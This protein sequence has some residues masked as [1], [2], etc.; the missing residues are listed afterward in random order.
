MSGVHAL[1]AALAKVQTCRICGL[2][3]PLPDPTCHDGRDHRVGTATGCP[4]CG[5]LQQACSRRPCFGSMHG[6]ARAK[7]QLTHLAR[8]LPRHVAG[9]AGQ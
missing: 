8:R 4:H 6:A 2:A 7:A 1:V 5:R 3:D 9:G